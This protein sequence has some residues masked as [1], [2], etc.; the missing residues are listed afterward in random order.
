ML[1][2]KMSV[3]GLPSIEVAN[4]DAR[5]L[6]VIRSAVRRDRI[7]DPVYHL[8]VDAGAFL[9][10]FDE[11]GGWALVEFWTRNPEKYQPFVDFLNTELRDASL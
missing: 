7:S 4:A 11:S 6:G 10:G 8:R 5:V 9:Q 2:V 3:H 1:V